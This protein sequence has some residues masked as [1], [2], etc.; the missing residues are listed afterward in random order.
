MNP[1]PL[2][3]AREAWGDELPDWVETL[4]V[5]CGRTSQNKVAVLLDRSAAVIS[6]V[7]RRKY[8]ASMAGIEERVRGVFLNARVACPACGD[9]PANE[10][11]DWREKA[12]E[13]APGNPVRVR[14]FRACNTCPRNKPKETEE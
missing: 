9:I 1:A 10:C 3:T 4:A 8:P 6:Q 14:M 11:Q 2:A 12:R 13:F 5:E 7:L